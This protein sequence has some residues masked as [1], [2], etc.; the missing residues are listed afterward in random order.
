M[1]PPLYSWPTATDSAAVP[2]LDGIAASLVYHW[3]VDDTHVTL[4]G[5]NVSQLD[6]RVAGVADAVQA[7]AGNQPA[8]TTAG[9]PNALDCITMQDTA[10]N[11]IATIS[12]AAGNRHGIYIVSSVPAAN[13]R[14]PTT[15]VTGTGADTLLGIRSGGSVAFEGQCAFTTTPQVSVLTVPAHDV[16]WHLH[17]LRP[18]AS[19]AVYEI[20]GAPVTT[21][22]TGS[23]TVRQ[24]AQFFLGYPAAV[25]G[26][27]FWACF[28]TSESG[29]ATT[30]AIEDYV[31]YYAG[32][33]M[34]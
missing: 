19:G 8:Y 30:Q 6:E 31:E 14:I 22:F 10:R 7:T 26:G 5:G 13:G 24:Y 2:T 20:D 25:S 21:D 15:F 18:L 9:G 17:A 16:L 12:V 32:I 11:M 29:D 1:P 34:A 28:V 4:N 33:V 27:T 23:D 3:Q